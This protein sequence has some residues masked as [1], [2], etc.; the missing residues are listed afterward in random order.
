MSSILPATFGGSSDTKAGRLLPTKED[1]RKC[2]VL[3]LEQHDLEAPVG[4]AR[5]EQAV[6]IRDWFI[7]SK[8]D[9]VDSERS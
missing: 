8:F 1:I 6:V 5:R 2:Q 3:P 9:L 4:S 7:A